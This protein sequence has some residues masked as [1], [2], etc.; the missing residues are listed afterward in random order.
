MPKIHFIAI[1]GAA[2]HNLAL[3]L[4]VQG[5]KITG[6]DDEIYEPSKSLLDQHGILPEHFGWYPE[7]I[8]TDL[9]CVIVG[10]HA[11][12]DN[13][14]LLKAQE[15]GLRIESY[16]SFLYEHS[17]N[18]QRIVIAGSHGKTSITSMV[19]HVLKTLHK[20]F[21]YLVGARLEGFD[22]MASLSD[23]PIIVIE[24]DEYLASPIDRRAKFLLYQ[25][26]IALISG[27]AWD[28]INVYPT[29]ESYT[30]SF[31]EL[32]KS[33]PK[34]GTLFFDQTDTILEQL[35]ESCPN[36]TEKTG[37]AAHPS[38]IK[39][40]QTILKGLDGKD[41]EIQIFGEH[42][43]KNLN[44]ARLLCEQVGVSTNDFYQAIQSF[45]GAAK[46]LEL[47][48][49]SDSCLFYK[50]FAHAPSK[51]KATTQAVK[52]QYPQ[53]KLIACLE[54]HTFSSLNP[55]FLPHYAKTLQAA[56]VAVIYLSEH[57][58]EIKRMDR[59]E[60]DQVQQYFEHPHLLIL[61]NPADLM[62]YLHTQ[63]WAQ[64]NLLMMSSGTFD[65][66]NLMD[67]A[68]QMGLSVE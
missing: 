13:P 20:K 21:D 60:D 62:A 3:A 10:M 63:S 37:Y 44:G 12:L 46:R 53:R 64:S 49:K 54:L 41:Y 8:T 43:L 56:D 32:I 18:K 19:L 61:R 11:R 47:V 45:K 35:T 5:Y 31:E 58:R 1:G 6:S 39:N 25:A 29:F 26:H 28:H 23:A 33:M 2:M 65:G 59:L 9:D 4:Q 27:I 36:H 48:G 34:A 16:P 55:A 40:G 24:G 38:Y 51:V 68:L 30:A 52:S 57:A 17:K 7:K 50:D 67:L 42:S 14:E 66:L 15:L 22:F